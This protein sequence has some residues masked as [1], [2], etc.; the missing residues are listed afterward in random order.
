LRPFR[1]LGI[2]R[3]LLKIIFAVT[4]FVSDLTDWYEAGSCP[5]DS[6]DLQKHA[7]LLMYRLF[8]WYQQ[9]EHN[10]IG[11]YATA[12]AL[13]QSVCLALLIFM[14]NATEPQ[15]GCF[16][17]RLSKVVKKLRQSLRS[18]PLFRWAKAPHI[19]F[20][21]STMGALGAKSLPRTHKLSVEDSRLAFFKEHINLAFDGNDYGHRPSADQLLD[22]MQFCLWISS[23][24]NERIKLLWVSM[25]ICE[26]TTMELDDI[27]SSSEG[28]LVDDEYALGQS[29][30]LRFFTAAK[31][32]TRKQSRPPIH[33]EP[34]L[35]YS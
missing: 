20:W 21:V 4:V 30:T 5:V 26:A 15:A 7:S 9:N 19:L 2:D 12:N 24:F 32:G 28:E 27:S 35:L 10:V 6:L 11:G 8:D 16:G 14:V 25:G 31:S 23:V 22:R 18:V 33:Q 1:E 29:T 34:G 13:H 3:S 17:S